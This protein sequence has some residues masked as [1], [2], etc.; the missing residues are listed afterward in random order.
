MSLIDYLMIV[1]SNFRRMANS[2]KDHFSYYYDDP[3]ELNNPVA[4]PAYYEN[5]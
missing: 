1:M 3:Y 2:S 4:Y 5:Q